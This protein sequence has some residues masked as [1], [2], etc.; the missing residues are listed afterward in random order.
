MTHARSKIRNAVVVALT[1]LN[2]TGSNIFESH[3]YP[4]GEDQL[5]A[6]T[7]HTKQ[8]SSELMSRSS[9]GVRMKRTVELVVS[10]YVKGKN[11]YDET[12]DTIMAEVEHA[13]QHDKKLQSLVKFI[14]PRDLTIDFSGEGDVP[15]AIA[16]Q[17]FQLEY[18]TMMNDAETII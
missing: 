17:A 12:I 9:S 4:V 13:I 7:V 5:P 2:T 3:V 16:S 1:D 15:I 18:H 8:E 14:Y 6:L 11:Q 10:A